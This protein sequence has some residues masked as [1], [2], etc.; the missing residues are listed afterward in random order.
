MDN[1]IIIRRT[2]P[3]RR[4]S[5]AS[6]LERTFLNGDN[7]RY[8]AVIPLIEHW[9]NNF[10]MSYFQYR[11]VLKEIAFISMQRAGAKIKP[12]EWYFKFI[13]EPRHIIAVPTDDD[14]L[15]APELFKELRAA[16]N[17]RTRIYLWNIAKLGIRTGNFQYKVAKFDK[18]VNISKTNLT[19]AMAGMAGA[20]EKLVNYL[21]CHAPVTPQHGRS[22][23]KFLD[24]SRIVAVPLDLSLSV[25][26]LA[27]VT[28]LVSGYV[29][30][31]PTCKGYNLTYGSFIDKFD[32]APKYIKVD[33]EQ[34]PGGFRWAA[35]Y[36]EQ[37]NEL[38]ER[39]FG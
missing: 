35:E 15:F 30:H 10:G 9:N 8:R 37:L 12:L 19:L 17:N 31:I 36:V 4:I 27:S 23:I 38:N 3:W 7:L 24:G 11:A 39:T 13:N 29:S 33:M 26:T 2:L 20:R 21:K 5:W 1:F 16:G 18:S 25:R 32:K 22:V 34:L 14:N 28:Q 6:F